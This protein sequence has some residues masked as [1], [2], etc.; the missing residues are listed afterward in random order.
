M[1]KRTTRQAPNSSKPRSTKRKPSKKSSKKLSMTADVPAVPRKTR[2]N[3]RQR[4]AWF[5]AR[6][7]APKV[8]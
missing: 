3:L 4:A 6:A 5:Q 8:V 7:G 2:E 1:A